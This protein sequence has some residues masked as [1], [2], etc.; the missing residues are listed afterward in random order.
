MRKLT[1][2]A[3]AIGATAIL[4]AC[5]SDNSKELTGKFWQLTSITEKVPAFQGV[6]PPAD[7][8]KYQIRFNTD[9]S[10]NATADCNVVG[11]TFKTSGKDTIE[12][13]PG[14]STL[15]FCPEGSYGDLFIHGLSR[16]KTYAVSKDVLTLTLNDEGTM[17]FVVGVAPGP[18][19]AATAAPTAAPTASPTAKPTPTPTPKPTPTPTPKPTAA[20]T[21]TPA[22]T[23]KPTPAPSGAPTPAPTAKPTPAPT[24]KPTPAP[25][26]K[27]TPAPTPAPTPPPG[28]GLTGKTWLLTAVTMTDPAF[29]GVVPP[30]QQANYTIAFATNGTFSAKADC[31][32]LNGAY[33]TTSSGGLT[34]TPGP[35]T[36]VA[37]ADGSYSDL[38]IMA[39]GKTASFAIANSQLTIT[40]TDQGT[41][42]YK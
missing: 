41:L 3:L 38:Y 13:T 40:L 17:T 24:P 8:T 35:S 36:L 37:C 4:A 11:G 5:G 18:T 10:F 34:L 31:N 22:P 28:S 1:L 25:T 39:L 23:A 26:P 30:D 27:P 15:A 29:Q 19:D 7:Q 9:G 2:I 32:T 16:A 21:A 42:V 20:P 33:T 14:M 6:I 12:I